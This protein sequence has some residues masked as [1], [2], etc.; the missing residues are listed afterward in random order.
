MCTPSGYKFSNPVLLQ[1]RSPQNPLPNRFCSVRKVSC[2]PPPTVFPPKMP[3]IPRFWYSHVVLTPTA[4][5]RQLGARLG[6]KIMARVCSRSS[7]L[8]AGSPPQWGCASGQA[9]PSRANCSAWDL[10][11]GRDRGMTY[12]RV[13]GLGLCPG[14][15]DDQRGKNL[16]PLPVG[17]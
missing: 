12:V 10:T 3:F 17:R 5:A 7:A 13:Q 2:P 14:R 15:G 16:M 4:R 11:W 1:G 6:P 9:H 8:L